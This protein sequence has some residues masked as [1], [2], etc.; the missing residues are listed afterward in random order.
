MTLSEPF[1]HFG[2]SVAVSDG[3]VVVGARGGV[4]S[5]SHFGAVSI[6][7]DKNNIT[8]PSGILTNLI[9]NILIQPIIHTHTNTLT[10]TQTNT[11]T[12]TRTVILLPPQGSKFWYGVNVAISGSTVAISPVGRSNVNK[13][14]VYYGCTPSFS[15]LSSSTCNDANRITL[16]GPIAN[17]RFGDSLS[18]SSNII[19][20]GAP[21]A[22]AGNGAAYIYYGT[23]SNTA[24]PSGIY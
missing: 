23:L 16:T 14:F 5:K 1:G 22:N 10:L 19:V 4:G 2:H 11:H 7:Y 21:S 24:T 13:V 20:F 17:S 12:H 3:T 18:V 6:F 9:R 8:A 15:S